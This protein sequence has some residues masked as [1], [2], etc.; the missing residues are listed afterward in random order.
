MPTESWRASVPDMGTDTI[1]Q[2]AKAALVPIARDR[3][4]V[5]FPIFER[6][7]PVVGSRCFGARCCERWKPTPDFAPVSEIRLWAGVFR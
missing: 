7:N 3:K 2:I 6:P 1:D 5:K 4:S